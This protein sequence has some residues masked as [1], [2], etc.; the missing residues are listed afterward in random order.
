M[1]QRHKHDALPSPLWGGVGGGGRSWLAQSVKQ[2]LP[3]TPPHPHKGGGSTPRLRLGFTTNRRAFITLAGAAAAW[4]LAART[5]QAMP[6][7]GF[8]HSA[9]PEPYADVVAAFRRGLAQTGYLEGRN[10]AIEYRWAENR[11]ERLPELAA[12]LIRRRVSVIAAGGPAAAQ[13]AKAAT[14]AIPI[15]FVVGADPVR[16]GLVTSLNRPGAN[17]TGVSFLINDLAPKQL[18]ILRE[19]VPKAKSIRVLVN[20]GNPATASD[21]K[22]LQAAARTLGLAL[23][24]AEVGGEHDLAPAF[25]QL[26]SQRVDGLV[27]V[28]DPL[29]FDRRAK[30]AALVAEH[31]LPTIY[32]VRDFPAAGGL[33]SYGSSLT[34]AFRQQGI[35]TGQI[36]KGAT[37]AEL[38][39]QQ[40]TKVDLV[41]NLKTAKALGLEVP[42][43]ILMRVDDVIE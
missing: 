42:M 34:E 10:V 36:L 30:I 24:V 1:N 17:L 20:P 15:A 40:S 29:M 7:V 33:V 27:V 14:S 2:P 31:A 28:S 37:P 43:S 41:L 8:L 11:N 38:P 13:A 32:P 26:A 6:A 16:L 4:P 21:A 18:E 35:F 3:P 9:S 19:L 23:I 22:E 5:Q 12:D 39:V 25:R